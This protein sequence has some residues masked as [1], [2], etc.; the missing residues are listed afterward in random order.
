MA[1]RSPSTAPR[2]LAR[3]GGVPTPAGSVHP[4]PTGRVRRPRPGDADGHRHRSAGSSGGPGRPRVRG[5]SRSGST[6]TRIPASP[7][8][9][10]SARD[11]R[12]LSRTVGLP[13]DP[14]GLDWDWRG[15]L[16]RL[17]AD[18]GVIVYLSAHARLGPEG[19]V[20]ILRPEARFG[21][22]ESELTLRDV[23]AA[24]KACPSRDKLL[25]LDIMRPHA[26][27]SVGVL[28]DDVAGRVLGELEGVPDE[29]PDR[30]LRG[31]GRPE[32]ADLG[33]AGPFGLQ[34][35]RGPGPAG[36][37]GQ[38]RPRPRRHRDRRGS[39]PTTSRPAR[40]DGP[41]ATAT[42][43]RSRSWSRGRGGIPRP[44]P[45]RPGD[46]EARAGVAR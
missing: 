21:H 5:S 35:L 16:S 12:S 44:V 13:K 42:P 20:R 9:P 2:G 3:C 29:A 39:W 4:L 43:G 33:D 14:P 46:S 27:P 23:L 32:V 25:I 19:E 31:L 8:D 7:T 30:P 45:T 36:R 22:L 41:G 28:D 24:L 38:G 1:E 11:Y 40:A 6:T 34:L 15:E 18:E 10:S 17:G 26:D 37:G